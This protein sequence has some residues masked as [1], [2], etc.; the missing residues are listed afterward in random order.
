MDNLAGILQHMFCVA[1]HVYQN[2]SFYIESLL[3]L[4]QTL[5]FRSLTLKNNVKNIYDL[6]EVR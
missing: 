5:K 2:L 3:E 6:A 4:Q 1:A